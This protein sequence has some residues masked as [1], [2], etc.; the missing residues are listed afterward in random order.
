MLEAVGHPV[1]KLL[2]I[3]MGSLSLGDLQPGEF[4]FLTDREANTL[5]QLVDDRIASVE[6]GVQP[7][8]H[9]KRPVK[10]QGWARAKKIKKNRKRVR[11]LSVNR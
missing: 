6:G 4:R 5:R 2:R 8:V 1:I 3:R 10:R 7:P 9:S 11:P